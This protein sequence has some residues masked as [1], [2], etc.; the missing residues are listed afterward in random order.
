MSVIYLEGLK[1]SGII[2]IAVFVSAITDSKNDQMLIL[3]ND[4]A[5]P[6]KEQSL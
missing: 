1:N 2:R 5:S 6:F 3:S 4:L